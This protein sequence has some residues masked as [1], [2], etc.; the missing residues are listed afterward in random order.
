ME[1]YV[2]ILQLISYQGDGDVIFHGENFT[3]DKY[4]ER[5]ECEYWGDK[6][7]DGLNDYMRSWKVKNL[8]FS[9]RC[10]PYYEYPKD[11]AK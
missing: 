10:A 8:T 2:I 6:L 3:T 4:T 9:Y 1:K 7:A 11:K 5:A